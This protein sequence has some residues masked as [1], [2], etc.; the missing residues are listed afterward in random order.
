MRVEISFLLLFCYIIV[1]FLLF[2]FYYRISSLLCLITVTYMNILY[3][4]VCWRKNVT[5]IFYNVY[6]F[7]TYMSIFSSC[8][9]LEKPMCQ[10]IY[11]YLRL[12][13][14]CNYCCFSYTYMYIYCFCDKNLCTHFVFIINNLYYRHHLA[15]IRH[16]C[17]LKKQQ[18]NSSCCIPT[19]MPVCLLFVSI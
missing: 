16:F 4:F 6:T 1:V 18:C 5:R 19:L 11:I 14:F 3:I 9:C 7:I 12:L 8:Y 10:Y 2:L 15:N 13:F 17:L